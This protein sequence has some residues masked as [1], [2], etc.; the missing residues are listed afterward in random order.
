MV[1][2]TYRAS[3]QTQPFDSPH[4]PEIAFPVKAVARAGGR[5]GGRYQAGDVFQFNWKQAASSE[6]LTNNLPWATMGWFHVFPGFDH[7][8]RDRNLFRLRRLATRTN[9]ALA[10][11]NHPL[12]QSMGGSQHEGGNCQKSSVKV[13]RA[14]HALIHQQCQLWKGPSLPGRLP[15]GCR[16]WESR[17]TERRARA[18]PT[19]SP[20]ASPPWPWSPPCACRPPAWH[21]PA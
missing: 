14:I 12:P 13:H 9:A 5:S 20:A 4:G 3:C 16:S 2:P 11:T 6:F 7:R 18:R 19:P 15:W 10:A 21:R 1:D 17:G 8:S